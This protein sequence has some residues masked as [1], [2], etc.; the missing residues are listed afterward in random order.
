M[1][2][3]TLSASGPGGARIL[4]SWSSARRYTVSATG[5]IKKPDVAG[6]TGFRVFPLDL[7]PSVTIAMEARAVYSPVDRRVCLC[8]CIRVNNLAKT[9]SLIQIRHSSTRAVSHGEPTT[10]ARVGIDAVTRQKVHRKWATSETGFAYS[11]VTSIVD[12]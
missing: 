10:S 12:A 8:L 7:R 2:A 1:S 11:V 4:V 9:K 6:D 5:P 3:H